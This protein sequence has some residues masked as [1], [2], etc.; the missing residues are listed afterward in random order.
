LKTV[1]LMQRPPLLVFL[2]LAPLVWAGCDSVSGGDSGED[3]GTFQTSLFYPSGASA[4]RGEMDL[5]FEDE[6]V[7]SE[8]REVTGTWQ[9][10]V[11]G[12]PSSASGALQGTVLGSE[13]EVHLQE[14]PE[15]GFILQGTYDGDRM[16][17][18]WATFT[19]DGVVPSG[20]FEA[21]RE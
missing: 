18:T 16:E 4:L 19:V 14:S 7:D 9:F 3:S 8:P 10:R 2:L 6:S 15:S 21:V 13:I 11:S 1:L 12:G 20:T 5:A 17:G